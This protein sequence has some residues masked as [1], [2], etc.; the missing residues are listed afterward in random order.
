MQS[1]EIELAHHGGNDNGRLPVTKLDF[2]EYG[3]Y[4]NGT[5]SAVHLDAAIADVSGDPDHPPHRKYSHAVKG[6]DEY[7][8]RVLADAIIEVIA[9]ESHV[10]D[11]NACVI[12]TGETASALVTVLTTMLAMSPDM[13][14]PS[15]LRQAVEQISK[16]I[17]RDVSREVAKGTFDKLGACQFRGRA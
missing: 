3:I 17:R 5:A 4:P 13:H 12:R 16:R 6:Y 11:V 7:F 9:R 8:E 14:V 10:T 2:A 15:H 1:V